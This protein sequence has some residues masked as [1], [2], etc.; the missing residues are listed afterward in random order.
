MLIERA[1]AEMQHASTTLP[2]RIGIC[3]HAYVLDQFDIS[4]RSPG[5][6]RERLHSGIHEAR[7]SIRRIRAALDLGREKLWP[8][9]VAVFDELKNLCRGLS[10][11]RDA[12]A[13][14]E[15]LDRLFEQTKDA[16]IRLILRGVLPDPERVA[17]GGNFGIA[18]R[19]RRD[20]RRRRQ[21][22]LL[23]RRR[24]AE[25]VGNIVEPVGRIVGRQE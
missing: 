17:A 7:K 24:D 22:A 20:L 16:E 6:S 11:V 2:K 13:V 23:Q 4:G 5:R 19:D 12:H 18:D 10:L 8:D 14:I 1:M 3:L 21:V 15:T 9:A 25:G